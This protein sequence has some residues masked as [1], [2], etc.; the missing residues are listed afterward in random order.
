M[1]TSSVF[2]S[3]S[4]GTVFTEIA[5]AGG[6]MDPTQPET[7]LAN[8]PYLQSEEVSHAVMFLLS[9]SYTTNI[10]ELTIK[11]VGEKM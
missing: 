6:L 11:P 10:S 9:T 5:V 2:Q 7:Q 3:V 4:P 8:M 1:I